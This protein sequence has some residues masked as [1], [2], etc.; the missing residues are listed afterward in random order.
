VGSGR[1]EA[2]KVFGKLVLGYRGL[3]VFGLGVW[4]RA[5]VGVWDYRC[6]SIVLI[7]VGSSHNYS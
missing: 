6:E 2:G 7:N 1:R 4:I 3:L 5:R